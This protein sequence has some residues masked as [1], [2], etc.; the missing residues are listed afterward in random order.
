MSMKNDFY[1]YLS[2]FVFQDINIIINIIIN[3]YININTPLKGKFEDFQNVLNF[4]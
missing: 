2:D 4:S 3:I 1:I